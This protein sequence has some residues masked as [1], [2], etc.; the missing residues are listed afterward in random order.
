MQ[1]KAG[2]NKFD[3]LKESSEPINVMEK[4]PTVPNKTITKKKRQ[5]CACDACRTSKKKCDGESPCGRC[6]SMGKICTYSAVKRTPAA[7]LKVFRNTVSEVQQ[8]LACTTTSNKYFELYFDC[9]NPMRVFHDIDIDI[10]SHPTTKSELLQYNAVL[11]TATRSF[12]SNPRAYH[13]FENR[14]RKLAS[15]L[16]DDFSFDTA[17]GYQLLTFHYWG[18]DEEKS[19]HLRDITI[20][21]IKRIHSR[22]KFDKNSTA[23]LM[24]AAVGLKDIADP[25]V[26]D[27]M[28]KMTALFRNVTLESGSNISPKDSEIV[29]LGKEVSVQFSDTDL[30]TWATLRLKVAQYL[31]KDIDT[32]PPDECPLK[33]ISPESLKELFTLL[34]KVSRLMQRAFNTNNPNIRI[35]QQGIA[36]LLGSFVL[37]A[38]GR[39]QVAFDNMVQFLELFSEQE[40]YASMTA[41][42]FIGLLHIAFRVSFYEKKYDIANRFSGLQRKLVRFLP[43]GRKTM[44]EDMELLKTISTESVAERSPPSLFATPI[45]TITNLQSDLFPN[46]DTTRFNSPPISNIFAGPSNPISTEEFHQNVEPSFLDMLGANLTESDLAFLSSVS[47]SFLDTLTQL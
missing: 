41:P 2:I 7:P 46:S 8:Q 37:Y 23:R 18:E 30:L 19:H 21:L 13:T 22:S 47:P 12:S 11:A 36:N 9:M 10:L 3:R 28:D 33:T 31:F 14:A 26:V 39:K 44:E 35:N 25:H 27:D 16:F 1:W 6:S 4:V 5:S 34:H 24:I 29:F 15:E 17:L 20:S 40:A 32:V 43:S 42:F 45:P 38:A